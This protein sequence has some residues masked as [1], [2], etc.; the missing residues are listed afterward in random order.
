MSWSATSS[1]RSTKIWTLARPGII[2]IEQLGDR[3][4]HPQENGKVNSQTKW[5]REYVNKENQ[6]D[7]LGRRMNASSQGDCTERG[8]WPNIIKHSYTFSQDSLA[9]SW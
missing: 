8:V 7:L 9:I 4:K 1:V 5:S 3:L 2:E 6:L